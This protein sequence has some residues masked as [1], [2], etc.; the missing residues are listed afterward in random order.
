[1]CG[2]DEMMPTIEA[3]RYPESDI[4]LADHGHLWRQAWTVTARDASSVTTVVRD[5]VLGYRLER[6]LRVVD[7]VLS[8]DYLATSVV[9]VDRFV[10]WAAHPLF[11][12]RSGTRIVL[13]GL[14]DISDAAGWPVGA[15]AGEG[16]SLDD[17]A[18]GESQKIF[19]RVTTDSPTASLVDADGAHL[20]LRWSRSDAPYVGIWLDHCSLSRLPVIALEP[21]NAAVDSL[22]VAVAAA[23]PDSPWCLGPRGSR[24][25]HMEL[26]LGANSASLPRPSRHP[27]E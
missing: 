11:A 21:T 9:D 5:D 20:T 6:T 4:E 25:W 15:W 10:L 7:A 19:A 23:R 14:D 26:E 8:L 24:A 12:H 27:Q 2:W 3:C 1:M 16:W 18:P 22:D 13:R 17:F